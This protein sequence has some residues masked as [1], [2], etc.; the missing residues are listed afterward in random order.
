MGQTMKDLQGAARRFL[1]GLALFLLVI[2]LSA[3]GIANKTPAP[4]PTPMPLPDRG[5]L[6]YWVVEGDPPTRDESIIVYASGEVS[7]EDHIT[8]RRGS[9]QIGPLGAERLLGLLRASG[10]TGLQEEYRRP[11]W[12]GIAFAALAARLDGETKTVRWES[13]AMPDKLAQV[14]QELEQF[15]AVVR[16][17][18]H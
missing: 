5:V 14:I 4:L 1:Q 12:R 10:F 8:G 15:L 2:A 6:L 18:A 11:R 17:T 13:N 3:C 9:Q 16:Q 7:Y